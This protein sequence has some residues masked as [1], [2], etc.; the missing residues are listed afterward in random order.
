MLPEL[1]KTLTAH[2]QPTQTAVSLAELPTSL[3]E[4]QWLAQQIRQQIDSGTPSE[5]IAVLARRHRELVALVPHLQAAGIAIN[6]ERRDNVLDNPVI[7]V[8]ELLAR[9]IEAIA[10]GEF[11]TADSLLPE[12]M[13]HPGLWFCQPGYLA[14]QPPS[15]AQPPN[16]GRG[17]DGEPHLP[18]LDDVADPYGVAGAVSTA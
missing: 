3:A 2:H 5:E 9:A 10:A 14:A 6:Y 1:D 13:A 15:V 18:T 7:Q 11:P 4:R 12:L 8:L 16:V 17:D